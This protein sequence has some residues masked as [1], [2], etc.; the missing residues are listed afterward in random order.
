MIPNNGS[1]YTLPPDGKV[2]LAKPTVATYFRPRTA[3]ELTASPIDYEKNY[4]SYSSGSS[5]VI[6]TIPRTTNVSNI[7]SRVE[8]TSDDG[9]FYGYGIPCFSNSSSQ[10]LFNIGSNS[11]APSITTDAQGLVTYSSGDNTILNNKGLSQYYDKTTVPSY[12]ESFLLTDM[13][14]SDYVDRTG[15]GPTVDDIGS[16]FK[17]NY[18]KLYGDYHWRFPVGNQKAFYME[19]TVGSELDDMASYS[20][21]SKEI[22]VTHSV[23]SKN[24][25]AEFIL[26]LVAREDGYGIDDN[27]NKITGEKTYAL[28]QINL[29][30]REDRKINGVSAKP[31]Q[32]VEFTYTYELC[33]N[34][35]SNT[36]PVTTQRGKLT[37]KTVSVYTGKSFENQHSYYQFDYGTGAVNNPD[38]NY[39]TIDAW[40]ELKPG[41]PTY[42]SRFPYVDQSQTSADN[43]VQAWKLK[44][45]TSPNGGLM[46]VTYE[47]DR[48]GYVQNKRVMKHMVFEGLTNIFDLFSMMNNNVLDPSKIR[49]T[50]NTS[51]FTISTYAA[52]A[53]MVNLLYNVFYGRFHVMNVP[54]N[55]VIFKLDDPIPVSN[56]S[57]NQ[58]V[59]EDYFTDNGIVMKE[60]YLKAH[61]LVTENDTRTEIVPLFAGISNDLK[62]ALSNSYPVDDAP[63]IGVLPPLSGSSNYTYGYV[64][65]TPYKVR[66][67][68][69]EELDEGADALNDNIVEDEAFN[70]IQKAAFD[71]FQRSL[72]DIV[73][74][75]T[76]FS[77]GLNSLDLLTGAR[78]EISKAMRALGFGT[79][80]MSGY[81]TMRV[82]IPSNVKYG[83]GS[84]VKSIQFSDNWQAISGE[85]TSNYKANYVYDFAGKTSGVASYESRI[86]NDESSF[87]QW[88]SYYDVRVRFPDKFNY[89]PTPIMELLYP[90]GSIGYSK[91]AVQYNDLTDRGYLVSEFYTAKDKPTLQSISRLDKQ[92]VSII[93]KNKGRLTKLF[94]FSQ[95]F[96]LETN[97]FHG[98]IKSNAIYK[99]SL[100]DIS[101]SVINANLLS[102]TTYNYYNTGEKQKFSDEKGAIQE[103]EVGIDYD[104]HADSRLISNITTSLYGAIKKVWMIP[105]IVPFPHS[106]TN[107]SLSYNGFYSHALVKHAN[108]SAILKSVETEYMGSKNLAENIVFDRYSGSVILSSLKDEFDDV[109]YSLDYPAHWYYSELRNVSSSQD[110]KISLTLGSNTTITNAAIIKQLSPGDKL[111][112]PNGSYAWVAKAYP[113]PTTPTYFLITESGSEFSI[114]AGT[115]DVIV[116]ASGRSNE[117]TATMQEISTKKNPLATPTQISFPTTEILSGGAITLRDRLNVLCKASGAPDPVNNNNSIAVGIANPYL[118]GIRGNLIPDNQLAWQSGRIQA[119]TADGVRKDGAYSSFI[120]Y[121]AKNT[122]SG[123]WFPLTHPSHPNYS[124]SLG[125][126]NWRKSGEGTLY[127]QY[128]AQIEIKDPLRINSALLYGYNPKLQLLPVAIAQNA[129]K[130]DIAFDG[131][132]DY[133]YYTTQLMDAYEPHFSFLGESPDKLELSSTYRHSGKY[134]TIIAAGKKVNATR[135]ITPFQEAKT[136][137]ADNGTNT[138][139][140]QSCDCINTFSPTEGEYVIGAW[141]KQPNN[142]A[143]SIEVTVYNSS[144]VII[145]GPTSFTAN[146]TVLDGWQRI[147]GTLIIPSGA[148]KITVSLKNNTTSEV[149]FDD[150]RMHP[151]QAGMVTTVYDPNT[152]LKTASHDGYNFTTFYNYDENNQLVRV[153]VE[154]SEGIKTI[155]ESEMS[156]YKQP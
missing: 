61:I 22:W 146:S 12:A 23:E 14:G 64:V 26:D 111:K 18:T 25:I 115:Y 114:A 59:K 55:I 147:E 51:A 5:P 38:F 101:N 48:Y 155:S 16:Y 82:Y 62:N 35:P 119:T 85:Y 102:K 29:Y 108:R 116:H 130:Q 63:A 31:V 138:G 148:A 89:T 98:K 137:H 109:L 15:N 53:S 112:F 92:P 60:L 36:N 49:Q 94:A 77:T 54:N 145:L 90:S 118:Y 95:G 99:A 91:V 153:R 100:A 143:G 40:G 152:L 154:T 70:P 7:I 28:K 150:F 80:L 126:Q 79:T 122:T 103:L 44:R 73:Y 3:S 39:G 81:N 156:V 88:D 34:Y 106:I 2:T 84:R 56:T 8:V 96:S 97:D 127:D 37:L 113:W 76:A 120:P 17:F 132:E 43:N 65:L 87:Y 131:F 105:S 32:V 58:K 129:H 1:S 6:T 52:A 125:I 33:Q 134:S 144:N 42:N 68:K 117:I 124:A 11:G 140:V 66:N 24:Y 46:E 10:V 83:G 71:F 47:A 69:E 78:M 141:V 4:Y 135:F 19:G 50:M 139:Q 74:Q 121:Y 136:T 67:P 123:E 27:G 13:H 128:G 41:S 142:S 21:G 107:G 45:I 151:F 72:T 20:A 30:A 104:I 86:S 149:Y 93:D 110:K 9:I 133:S 57:A 75:N